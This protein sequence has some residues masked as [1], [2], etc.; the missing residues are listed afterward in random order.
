MMDNNLYIQISF[1]STFRFVVIYEVAQVCPAR[2][3]A[4]FFS[5]R[6]GPPVNEKETYN[7]SFIIFNIY[8]FTFKKKT[9]II[10]TITK[11]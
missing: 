4:H 7:P 2:C 6:K 11:L 9:S 10:Y 8:I 1:R 5:E 3:S